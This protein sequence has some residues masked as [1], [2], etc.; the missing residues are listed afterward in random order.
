MEEFDAARAE[1]NRDET[2][3]SLSAPNLRKLLR[4]RGLN[5]TLADTKRLLQEEAAVQQDARALTRVKRRA[6][7]FYRITAPPFSFQTDV[8]MYPGFEHSNGGHNQMLVI[9]EI[10]SR[11]AWVYP[12]KN[13]T[14]S[15][16]LANFKKFEA[17]LAP[18]QPVLVQ[19][20][21]GFAKK[22]FKDHMAAREITLKTNV[23]DKDHIAG[24]DALGIIDRFSRTL[25]RY[26]MLRR[27]T[28]DGLDPKWVAHLQA[29]VRTYNETPHTTHASAGGMSPNQV[30]D[31]FDELLAKRVDDLYYNWGMWTKR[32]QTNA[33][34]AI[35]VGDWVRVLKPR[36]RFDKGDARLYV[37]KFRVVGT[38]GLDRYMLENAEGERERRAFK[39]AELVKTGAP[40]APTKPAAD[41]DPNLAPEARAHKSRQR[42]KRATK[43][44]QEPTPA[45]QLSAPR[46]TRLGTGALKR[47]TWTR[48]EVG[49]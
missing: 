22:D 4:N 2:L 37:E 23:A 14:M 17:E 16:V 11:K 7:K 47:R 40:T 39:G 13:H 41:P 30:F 26:L 29:V 9:I 20:D 44:P 46:Q 33:D 21:D 18:M 28:A 10:L 6:K 27:S 42:F 32:M 45:A 25:R 15:T 34:E 12:M 19:A 24:G 48:R 5:L 35:R 36:G 1:L 43:L 3:K 49:N 8:I 31:S 38:K